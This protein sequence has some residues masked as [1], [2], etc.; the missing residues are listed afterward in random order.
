MA[1]PKERKKALRATS[2]SCVKR[3]AL[4]YA[5]ATRYK[6]FERVSNSFLEAVEINA[7]NFIKNRINKH[8]SRGKTLT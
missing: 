8:P 5:Q 7:I 1:E 2:R 4:S 3:I 6:K